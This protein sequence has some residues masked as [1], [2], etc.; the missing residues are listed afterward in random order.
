MSIAFFN[1]VDSIESGGLITLNGSR[2]SE[3]VIISVIDNGKG[4]SDQERLHCL[5]PFYTT[6]GALGTGLGLSGVFGMISRHDGK[7]EINSVKGEGTEIV[8]KLPLRK[9]G[10]AIEINNFT[11]ILKKKLHILC[12]DDDFRILNVLKEML[13]LDGHSVAVY[14]NPLEALKFIRDNTLD[15]QF[16]V[17]FTDLGMVE[18]NGYDLAVE[19]KNISFTSCCPFIRL[20][21]SFQIYR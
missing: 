14:N 5:E 7:L 12:I 2:D 1:S 21:Q 8:I 15:R 6:K 4:M 9:A 16:D 19:I 20:E 3:F 18:M 17:V 13:M 10:G 11:Y